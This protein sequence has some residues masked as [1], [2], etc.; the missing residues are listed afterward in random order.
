MAYL[1]AHVS[2]KDN[3]RSVSTFPRSKG[4]MAAIGEKVTVRDNGS[5]PNFAKYESSDENS[6]GSSSYRSMSA[7]V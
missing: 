7:S 1:A 6:I 5:I 4:D 2:Q 3:V